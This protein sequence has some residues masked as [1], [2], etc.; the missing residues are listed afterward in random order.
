MKLVYTI[1]NIKAGL[2]VLPYPALCQ[3]ANNPFLFKQLPSYVRRTLQE[4]EVRTSTL[5]IQ[6]EAHKPFGDR[7]VD[8]KSGLTAFIPTKFRE[9]VDHFLAIHFNPDNF[10]IQTIFPEKAEDSLE[11]QSAP[12]ASVPI[13]NSYEPLGHSLG[14]KPK[15]IISVPR[16]E[17]FSS[18]ASTAQTDYICARGYFT[19][20][21]R[22]MNQLPNREIVDLLTF[23]HLAQ[24]GPPI[25]SCSSIPLARLPVLVQA[26]VATDLALLHEFL[27][28]QFD[29]QQ[30]HM[31]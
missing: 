25:M 7:V 14:F 17:S 30:S 21:N 20:S 28:S 11:L 31:L 26:G 8:I 27:N 15:A 9:K 22:R 12:R 2:N 1:K 23:G 24:E 13:I 29:L 3:I 19:L 18:G 16:P 4:G 6:Q 10:L 5:I